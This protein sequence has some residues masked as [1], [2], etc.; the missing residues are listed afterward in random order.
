MSNVLKAMTTRFLVKDSDIKERWREYYVKFLNEDYV[1]DIRTR[2]DT[3]LTKHTFFCRGGGSEESIGTNQ[4]GTE[5][6]IGTN[7]EWKD[8][9]IPL[10]MLKRN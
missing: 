9:D 8:Y 10:E 4:G 2:D 7:Q 5:K 3:Q 1:G 6:R